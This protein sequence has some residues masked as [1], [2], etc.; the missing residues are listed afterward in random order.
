MRIDHMSLK[1]PNT[2]LVHYRFLKISISANRRPESDLFR[3]FIQERRR[4]VRQRDLQHFVHGF[5]EVYGELVFDVRRNIG[6]ILL[7]ILGKDD[8]PNSSP[9]SRQQLLFDASDRQYLSP[10]RDFSR[11]GHI[12]SHWNVS[13]SAYQRSRHRDTG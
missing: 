3:G 10:K 1:K 12:A 11:H 7:V 13:E 9:M 8:R 4:S 6:E 2:S 5:D